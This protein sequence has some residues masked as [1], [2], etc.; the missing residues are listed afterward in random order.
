MKTPRE[1]AVLSDAQHVAVSRDGKFALISYGGGTPPE[2]WE[3]PSPQNKTGLE[4]RKV[5]NQVVSKNTDQKGATSIG[6]VGKAR[7]GWVTSE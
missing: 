3:L 4:L 6:I 5:Y 7:F 2:L 1:A